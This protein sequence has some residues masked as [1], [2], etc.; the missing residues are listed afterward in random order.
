[1]N[2]G[3]KASDT[4][5][6]QI[7]SVEEPAA[8]LDNRLEAFGMTQPLQPLSQASSG[9]LTLKNQPLNV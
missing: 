2:A 4:V 1:M 9:I 3:S 6:T 5:R 7:G 8:H